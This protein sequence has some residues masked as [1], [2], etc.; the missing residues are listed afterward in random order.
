MNVNLKDYGYRIA[1]TTTR[2]TGIPVSLG[3]APTKALTKVAVRFA[4]K[5]AGYKGLCVIDSEAKRIKA[6]QMTDISDVWG[7]GRQY[8]KKLRAKGVN[9]AYDFACLPRGWVRKEMTVIGE[10]LYRELNGEKCFEMVPV[11][12]PKKQILSSKSFGKDIYDLPTI[13]EEVAKLLTV[14]PDG[15]LTAWPVRQKFNYGDPYDE[16]IIDEVAE[17]QELDL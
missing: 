16:S 3:I 4:K 5:Y 6:L 2:C 11:A 15:D 10:S 17:Q 1:E 12:P 14:F 7:I 13:Q 8:E 9:T